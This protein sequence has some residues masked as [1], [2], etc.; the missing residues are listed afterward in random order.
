MN[1]MTFKEQKQVMP[2][3]QLRRQMKIVK[4]NALSC[5]CSNPCKSARCWITKR[6]ENK[7]KR[8]EKKCFPALA[9]PVSI[10]FRY[11]PL[12]INSSR[13]TSL[14]YS[15]VN[16]F[17]SRIFFGQSYQLPSHPRAHSAILPSCI[18]SIRVFFP[19]E[20]RFRFSNLPC[21]LHHIGN[22]SWISIY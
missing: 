1:N 22:C 10:K 13:T 9:G 6:V 16:P 18:N 11:L 2:W 14:K 19:L 8:V 5:F 4:E 15:T 17:L 20:F 3:Q 21:R 7:C 12:L